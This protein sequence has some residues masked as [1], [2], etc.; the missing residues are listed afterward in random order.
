MKLKFLSRFHSAGFT[1][2]ELLIV[3]AILGILA[4]LVLSA[5][6]P[7]EQINRG[8]DT[9]KRSD[10]EQLLSAVER[11]NAFQTTF[12]WR[13]SNGDTM[14]INTTLR[15][16]TALLPATTLGCPMMAKLAQGQ[17]GPPVCV[18]TEELK[19]SYLTRVTNFAAA[20]ALYIFN[21]DSD[22]PA[23]N[24]YVC[25]S[26]ESN[27]F[28]QEAQARC[29]GAAPTDLAAV[30]ADGICST[31]ADNAAGEDKPMICLP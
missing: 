19:A 16:V 1:M 31:A 10:A 27:A 24:T 20:R 22:D 15:Q 3:I 25:F 11:F 12:P 14:Q 9:A 2:I 8:R 30:W 7:L 18:G 26:P 21:N 17:A 6:N 28:E 5:I 29:D 13:D 23:N 4:V